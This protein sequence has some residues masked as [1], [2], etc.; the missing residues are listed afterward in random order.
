MLMMSF[1]GGEIDPDEHERVDL[2]VYARGLAL[3]ENIISRPHGG[4]STRPGLHRFARLRHQL[5]PLVIDTADVTM[6]NGGVAADVAAG[7]AFDTV[8][9]LPDAV[10]YVI[11]EIDFG[12]PQSVMA[13]DLTNYYLNDGTAGAGTGV[14]GAGTGGGG[15]PSDPLPPGD[16]GRDEGVNYGGAGDYQ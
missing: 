6:D 15:S 10:D 1:N 14:P 11:A 12:A 3:A 7:A 8:T 13:L 16:G 9:A 2:D 4:L 5:S